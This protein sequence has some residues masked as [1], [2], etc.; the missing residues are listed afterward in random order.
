MFK[1]SMSLNPGSNSLNAP[2]PPKVPLKQIPVL[3]S[4]LKVWNPKLYL[5]KLNPDIGLLIQ[6]PL[7]T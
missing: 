5:P 6:E 1:L 2:L 3:L 4:L 7:T